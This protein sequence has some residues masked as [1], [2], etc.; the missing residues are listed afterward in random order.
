MNGFANLYGFEKTIM[1]YLL[2]FIVVTYLNSYLK[3]LQLQIQHLFNY[4]E[5]KNDISHSVEMLLE[6]LVEMSTFYND[7]FSLYSL[8]K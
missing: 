1:F 6:K 8:C 5:L 2:A 7:F 3:Q 4:F